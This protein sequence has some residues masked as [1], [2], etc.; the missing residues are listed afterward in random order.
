MDRTTAGMPFLATYPADHKGRRLAAIV[1]TISLALF[2]AAVPFARVQLPAA[3]AFILIY[4]SALITTDLI[5]AILLFSQAGILKSGPLRVLA[6]GYLYTSSLAALHVLSF[7]GVFAQTGLIG[8]GKQT[9]A[10]LY[11]FWHAGFPLYVMTYARLRAGAGR[12][13]MWTHS[14][15]P[16]AA[17]TLLFAA[18]F[19]LLATHSD[20]LLPPLMLGNHY[21]LAETIASACVVIASLF[22]LLMLALRR[23]KSVLDIWLMVVCS[24][25]AFDSS[26]SALLNAGR[27]DLGFYLGRG[28]GMVAATFVLLMILLENNT[29]YTRLVQLHISEQRKTEEL[30]RARDQQA[31]ARDAAEASNRTKSEFL[32]NMSH[33]IRTPMNAVLGL[34][35]LI[36]QRPLD[37]ESLSLVRKIRN[38]GNLLQAIIN[39]ILDFSKIEAGRLEIENAPFCLADVLSNLATIMANNVGEKAVELAISP[40]PENAQYLI[41]DALRLGQVLI[42]LTSNAIKFTERGAVTVDVQEQEQDG[43]SLLRFTIKDTGIGISKEQQAHIFSAFTQ[44]DSSTTRRFGGSGL[45]LAISRQLVAGMGGEIGVESSP[46]QGSEFWFTVKL[47]R[48][49]PPR[50]AAPHLVGLR[51]LIASSSAMLRDNLAQTARALGWHPTTVDSDHLAVDYVHDSLERHHGYDVVVLDW[52]MPWMDG[53]AAA[54]EIRRADLHHGALPTTIILCSAFAREELL[55]RPGS[56]ALHTILNKPVTG[57]TLYDAVAAAR[58]G[59]NS[60]RSSVRLPR[61]PG[62]RILVVDDSEINREVAQR[63]LEGEGAQVSLAS[64]GKAAIDGLLAAPG[65]IDLVLMDAQMPVMDGYEATRAIRRHPILADLPVVALTAGAFREQQEQARAAGMDD[66][67]AKPFSVEQLL[68]TILR[69][70]GRVQPAASGARQSPAPEQVPPAPG[71]ALPGIDQEQGLRAWRDIEV[72]HR[73][74]QKFAADYADSAQTLDTLQQQGDVAAARALAHKLKG[75]AGNL[76]LNAVAQAAGELELAFGRGE[77]TETP[78]WTLAAALAEVCD[79]IARLS[80]QAEAPPPPAVTTPPLANL[81]RDLQTALDSDS[82]ERIDP[83]LA[84]LHAVLAPASLASLR[85]RI[86]NFDYRG[87]EAVV[88]ALIEGLDPEHGKVG[89]T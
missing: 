63:I 69:L 77:A 46:G 58:M 7:P 12:A 45:G 6:C 65:T 55:R 39:D 62:I 24:A 76:A 23:D 13:R 75:A 57:S 33:E 81:L 22:A 42:N 73:F 21:F 8:G 16:L 37:A 15:P 89:G 60:D 30:T 17:A 19:A 11:M 64:N 87:A 20:A 44:A 5:T 40:P 61:L 2:L 48:A 66:F 74:L 10:W 25:W 85:S 83:A 84:P 47:Q 31:L 50:Y 35:Y 28:Y 86:D 34:A 71:L 80:G 79:S 59:T 38:A 53:L 27:F 41:G 70:T 68:Q 18:S 56:E 72:Y 49:P 1:V 43:H 29:L 14:S 88:A 78:S 9:T 67:V 36:E 82:P 52:Q 4:Q 26:L 3:P 51:I 54:L 32:A